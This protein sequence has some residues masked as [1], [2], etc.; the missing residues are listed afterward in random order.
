MIY[1]IFNSEQEAVTTEQQIV[2][3]AK[4]WLLSNSPQSLSPDG[5]KLRGRNAATGEFVEVYTE[6]W[7]VPQQTIDGKWVFLKPTQIKTSPI[8]V[9]VFLN[10]I[11]ADEIEYDSSWFAEIY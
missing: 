8:P 3:N 9:E 1:Y 6:K 7:A 11:I 4:N 2:D 5:N 10:N